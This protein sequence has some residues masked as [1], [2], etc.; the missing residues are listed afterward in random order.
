MLSQILKL[1]Q[2][3]SWFQISILISFSSPR[4]VEIEIDQLSL[5]VALSLYRQDKAEICK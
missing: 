5:P 4:V 3:L 1:F 2:I